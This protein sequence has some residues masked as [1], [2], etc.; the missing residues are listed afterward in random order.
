MAD[1]I[2]WPPKRAIPPGFRELVSIKVTFTGSGRVY[3]SCAGCGNRR[4]RAGVR[5]LTELYLFLFVALR[6]FHRARRP[7]GSGVAY[8]GLLSHGVP[9][10]AV[11]VG[12]GR[13]AW[14]VSQ[15]A[16]EQ[17]KIKETSVG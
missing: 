13:E 15:R 4:G 17:F 5:Y 3:A 2:N 9:R 6:A 7:G 1:E 12:V 8:C 14:R 11:F 16:V 10:L